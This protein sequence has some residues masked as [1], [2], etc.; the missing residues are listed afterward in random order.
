[1]EVSRLLG[2]LRPGFMTRNL[3]MMRWL[4]PFALSLSLLVASAC[5]K[6]FRALD[7]DGG[8]NGDLAVVDGGVADAHYTVDIGAGAMRPPSCLPELGPPT[9]E[10]RLSE[11]EA[12]CMGLTV[13]ECASCHQ[14]ANNHW[15]L[16]PKDTPRPPNEDVEA[17]GHLAI[18]CLDPCRFE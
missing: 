12:E 11:E 2:R 7:R 4:F 3:H 14:N 6:S 9:G 8:E 16:R 10:V 1:M 17:M 13:P 18:E 5:T 15:L